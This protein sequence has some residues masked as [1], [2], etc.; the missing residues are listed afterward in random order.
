MVATM[1]ATMRCVIPCLL[2]TVAVCG[3]GRRESYRKVSLAVSPVVG[4]PL[5]ENGMGKV[6]LR[7][8][9]APVISPRETLKSYSDLVDY[10]G[11]RL[12]RPAEIIQRNS[13]AEVNEL[14]RSGDCD[15]AF[16]CSYP[17][18]VGQRDFGMEA[19]VIPQVKGSI[20]YY[21]YLIVPAD[22]AAEDWGDLRGKV[23]AF[24]DPLSNSGHLAPRYQLMQRGE[25]PEKFFK[26]T[27]F[28]YSHDKSIRAVADKLVDGAAVDSI[29]YDYMLALHPELARKTKIIGKSQPFGIP[30]VVVHPRIKPTLRRQLKQAFLDMH[31]QPTGRAALK[32][33]MVDQFVPPDDHIYDSLREV[34]AKVQVKPNG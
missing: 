31:N 20:H 30:P 15:V 24:S 6:A 11:K 1:S 13:Y 8:V 9:V 4:A 33:L 3:C 21:S 12:G 17:Y 25:T 7:V 22:S 34:A 2:L 29:V 16:V 27:I 26:K 19:L 28:T 5:P 23:F 14:V 32:R 10:L 18:L